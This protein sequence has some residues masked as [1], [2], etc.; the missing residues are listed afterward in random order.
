VP[1]GRV[2]DVTIYE[3][4]ARREGGRWL[5]TVPVL[6]G[7]T[8]QTKRLDQV[9]EQVRSLISLW[10]DTPITEVHVNVSFQIDPM[11][12][13]AV[14]DLVA[15]R[16]ELAKLTERVSEEMRATALLMAHEGY[17]MR[18][19]GAV[20]GTSYQRAQQLVSSARGS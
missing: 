2:V 15:R 12:A 16:E 1:T 19:I 5:I 11:I 6:D 10:M 18:D 8:T 14:E 17:T 4:V 20:L 9:D 7:I 3:A 13:S